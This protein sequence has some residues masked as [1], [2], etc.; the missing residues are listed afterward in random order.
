[1]LKWQ[2]WGFFE[3]VDLTDRVEDILWSHLIN[4]PDYSYVGVYEGGFYYSKGVWRSEPVS[5]MNNNIRYINA[6]G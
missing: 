5:L 3:N 1:M 2:Q 4:D 6:Q